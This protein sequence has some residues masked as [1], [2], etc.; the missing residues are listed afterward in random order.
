MS[1]FGHDSHVLR[2]RNVVSGTGD[3]ININQNGINGNH[4]DHTTIQ[5]NFI[6]TAADSVTKPWQ[7][8]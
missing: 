3:G 6:G 7:Q 4:S 2:R 5:G 1:V 8:W